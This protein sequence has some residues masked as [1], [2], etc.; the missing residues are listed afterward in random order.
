MVY[1]FIVFY[2]LFSLLSP[3]FFF[4]LLSH[5]FPLSS[6]CTDYYLYTCL[7]G[8]ST[9][10][11]FSPATTTARFAGEG[12]EDSFL[13]TCELGVVCLRNSLVPSLLPLFLSPIP[14]NLSHPLKPPLLISPNRR[15]YCSAMLDLTDLT[16]RPISPSSL[17]SLFAFHSASLWLWGFYFLF[18]LLQFGLI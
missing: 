1:I 9:N 5:R 11:G 14:F 18:F 7:S 15:Q 3:H 10:P 4:S 17:S 8:S 6:P 16:H 13:E 2:S 12:L